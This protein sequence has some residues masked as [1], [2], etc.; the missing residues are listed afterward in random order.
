MY[1]VLLAVFAVS[2]AVSIALAQDPVS[3]RRAAMKTIGQ[4]NAV[5]QPMVRGNAPYDQAKVDE[6]LAAWKKAA[7][8]LPSLFP[9]ESVKGP[10][11]N[12]NFY[13]SQKAVED[14]PDLEARIAKFQKSIGEGAASVKDVESLKTFLSAMGPGNCNACH[15]VYRAR[16]G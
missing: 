5:L 7:D 9:A 14:R 12:S 16:K 15:E 1:R 11:A 6:A 2:G 3:E 13:A 4:H 10:D 8:R